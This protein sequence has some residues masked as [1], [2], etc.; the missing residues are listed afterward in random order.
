MDTF[1]G[2]YF[3][4]PEVIDQV[5]RKRGDGDEGLAEQEVDVHLIILNKL[6]H[7]ANAEIDRTT[8]LQL[9]L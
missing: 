7:Q 1:P 5:E 6:R 9:A 3:P 2:E 4:P 8:S